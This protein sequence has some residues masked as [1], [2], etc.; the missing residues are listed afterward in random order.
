MRGL[1]FSTCLEFCVEVPVLEHCQ[2]NMGERKL[3]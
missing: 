1:F 2:I 3:F